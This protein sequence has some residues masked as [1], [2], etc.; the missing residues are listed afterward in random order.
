MC[1]SLLILVVT[2]GITGLIASDTGT[3]FSG[4]CT[5]KALENSGSCNEEDL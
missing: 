5:S 2:V 4:A 3:F 1:A